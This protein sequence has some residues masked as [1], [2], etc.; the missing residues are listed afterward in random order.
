MPFASYSLT[1]RT[2][3][4]EAFIIGPGLAKSGV[5]VDV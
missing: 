4:S 3:L 1:M 5:P 2:T